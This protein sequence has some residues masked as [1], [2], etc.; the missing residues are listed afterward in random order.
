MLL[1][2]YFFSHKIH[3]YQYISRCISETDFGW[4]Y[5]KKNIFWARKGIYISTRR[6][7]IQLL[8]QVVVSVNTTTLGVVG[9][10]FFACFGYIYITNNPWMLGGK[11]SVV[12]AYE[13]NNNDMLNSIFGFMI[14]IILDFTI[15]CLNMLILS[16]KSTKIPLIPY[17]FSFMFSHYIL[18]SLIPSTFAAPLSYPIGFRL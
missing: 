4:R 5:W 7:S 14:A 17:C 6:I 2:C 12:A 1:H 15:I 11:H 9:V 8:Y 18:N 3:S 13:N 16:S 10:D